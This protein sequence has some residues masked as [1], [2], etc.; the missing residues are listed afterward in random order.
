M[1]P[2]KR[3]RIKEKLLIREAGAKAKREGKP[4]SACP[5]RESIDIMNRLQWLRGWDSDDFTEDSYHK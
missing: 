2:G 5:Y 1:S 4:E 3:L